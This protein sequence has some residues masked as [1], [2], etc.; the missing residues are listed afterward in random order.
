MKQSQHQIPLTYTPLEESFSAFIHGIGVVLSLSMLSILVVFAVIYGSTVAIMTSA[1]FGTSMTVVFF[2]STLYHSAKNEDMKV[3]LKRADHIAIYYLIAG[4]Y[5]PFCLVS[6]GGSKGWII[7]GIIW[8]LAIVGTLLKIF[9]PSIKGTKLWSLGL[10]LLMGWLALFSFPWFINS[11]PAIGLRFLIAGGLC[12]TV[13]IIFY[14]MKKV[15]FTHA[16]WH[17]FVLGGAIFHFF[18][19]LYSCV[20]PVG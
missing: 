3:K 15:R 17:L 14:V 7:F 16:I 11:L 20:L 5:T 18:A 10:Y 19:V 8:T 6:L 9:L 12:Y 13:G 2:T 1:I 4:T